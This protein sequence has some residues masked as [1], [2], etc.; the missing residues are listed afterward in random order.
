MCFQAMLP[1][2]SATFA[3]HGVIP[4]TP[5]KISPCQGI[6]SRDVPGKMISIVLCGEG[7]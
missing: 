3:Q 4:T 6:W 1:P 2:V 5:P 7:M